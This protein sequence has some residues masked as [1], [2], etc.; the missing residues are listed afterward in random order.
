AERS[1]AELPR[2]TETILVAEDD[3]VVRLL[4]VRTLREAGY[5]VLEADTAAAGLAL[6]AAHPGPIHLLLTD[7]VMPGGSGRDLA[8]ALLPRW[9]HLRVIFMSG[10]T[11][12]VVLRRG[13]VEESVR[14]LAK[15][16]SPLALAH[17]VRRELDTRPSR[18]RPSRSG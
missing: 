1:L 8:E 14:F 3:A 13:V 4:A 16:F 18:E 9:P 15:P 6:A 2:G 17:A 5:T 12:D 7:V 11:S 10:Y